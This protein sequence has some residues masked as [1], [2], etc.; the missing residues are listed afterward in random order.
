MAGIQVNC[1]TC[2]GTFVVDERATGKMA[3]CPHCSAQITMAPSYPPGAGAPPASPQQTAQVIYCRQCGTQN[4]VGGYACAKCGYPLH[5]QPMP[6]YVADPDAGALGG[7]IPYRNPS[8]LV[9][10]YLAVFSLIP[11][12]GLP[13]GLGGLVMGIVG[14]RY[15]KLHPEAKGAAH[16]WTGVILGGLCGI[17]NLVVLILIIA[18]AARH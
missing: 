18:E 14:L 1:P 13:L 15:A 3:T 7:L 6:Q 8:A 11:C 17:A 12:L 16:A 9:A 10:Y 4:A 2:H 5:A